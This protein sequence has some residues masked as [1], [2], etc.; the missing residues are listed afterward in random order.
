MQN[1]TLTALILIL[2]NTLVIGDPFEKCV[3]KN[4]AVLIRK[5]CYFPTTEQV[6]LMKERLRIGNTAKF[7]S[8]S[9]NTRILTDKLE[10]SGSQAFRV[11]VCV[12]VF[13]KKKFNTNGFC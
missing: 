1:V 7:Q 5:K 10:N 13:A 6:K 12:C 9:T 2:I 8:C 11:C 3:S 4:V